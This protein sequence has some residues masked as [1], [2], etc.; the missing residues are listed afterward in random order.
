MTKLFFANF[1]KK[2]QTI[3]NLSMVFCKLSANNLKR[4]ANNSIISLRLAKANC[5]QKMAA[6]YTMRFLGVLGGII[7]A[8]CVGWGGVIT[9]S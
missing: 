4:V 9:E 8:T 5:L 6:L 7:E 1:L 3:T 2:V